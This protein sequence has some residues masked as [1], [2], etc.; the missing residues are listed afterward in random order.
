LGGRTAHKVGR[1]FSKFAAGGPS[2]LVELGGERVGGW[3][4]RGLRARSDG[5][6]EKR[7]DGEKPNGWEKKSG[8]G[9]DH[10]TREY[11]RMWEFVQG[12]LGQ[13]TRNYLLEQSVVSNSYKGPAHDAVELGD[14]L[15]GGGESR[16][17]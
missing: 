1:V 13:G 5:D 10:R 3:V 6:G 17:V 4:R 2:E 9:R 15:D 11:G 16:Q 7:A 12:S 8:H 14:E